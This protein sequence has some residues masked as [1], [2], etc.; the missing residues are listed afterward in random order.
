MPVEFP[1]IPE[2]LPEILRVIEKSFRFTYFIIYQPHIWQKT[3]KQLEIFHP[4]IKEIFPE[5]DQ[6]WKKKYCT[7]R[8]FS[9]TVNSNACPIAT[10]KI[11]L[12]Y[13]Q[14]SE[15]LRSFESFRNYFFGINFGFGIGK[16]NT[17]LDSIRLLFIY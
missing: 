16:T 4:E 1:E 7:G 9:I 2:N 12:Y 8:R 15:F 10:R 3:K 11:F 13:K 17:R 5:F 14:F 6:Y